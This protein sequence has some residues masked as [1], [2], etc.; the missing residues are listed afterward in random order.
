MAKSSA[1]AAED[2]GAAVAGLCWEAAPSLGWKLISNAPPPRSLLVLAGG[3]AEGNL[4]SIWGKKEEED[5]PCGWM[6]AKNNFISKSASRQFCAPTLSVAGLAQFLVSARLGSSLYNTHTYIM[7]RGCLRG[8]HLRRGKQQQLTDW[9]RCP[10]EQI[11]LA[12]RTRSSS[13]RS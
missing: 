1:A 4:G 8:T 9:R 10:E 3:G 11:G 13:N 12:G 6:E 2:P 5:I 7:G